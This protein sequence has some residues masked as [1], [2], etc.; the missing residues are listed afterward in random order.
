MRMKKE[1]A[2]W[3]FFWPLLLTALRRSFLLRRSRRAMV[4]D[5]SRC[6]SGLR[7]SSLALA[8]ATDYR[9]LADC[10]AVRRTDP[11]LSP[12]SDQLLDAYAQWAPLQS[13]LF[14][15]SRFREALSVILRR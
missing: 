13:A 11:D 8:S 12:T 7:S 1:P 5:P 9:V 10:F 6:P 15:Y 3:L 2:C 4:A 14:D